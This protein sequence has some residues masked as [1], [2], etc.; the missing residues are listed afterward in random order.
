MTYAEFY[1][2]FM[3]HPVLLWA[4]A[5]AGL[6]IA[7]SRRGLSKSVRWFCIA[8]TALSLLD[9]WLTTD[10]VPGIGQL[11]GAAASL[12]PLAFVLLGDFR[13]FLF[14][15]SAR[16]DGT[17][18]ASTA[19]VVKAIGWTLVVPLGSQLVVTG[20]ASADPRVLF[21][22]YEAL[23][24]VLALCIYALYLPRQG[25]AV[26]WTRRV[27]MFVIGYYALWGAADA[28]ILATS[29]DMGFLLRVLPNALYYGGLVPAIAWTAP[30]A[31]PQPP[32]QG[33]M[34]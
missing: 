27:T 22:V 10:H 33:T 31:S 21:L 32:R 12:V 17:L 5:L 9:A 14:I 34:R 20:I 16:S 24:A 7:L 23:F 1:G 15:E 26:Q 8:L 28:I 19:G 4:S 2:S 30:R 25:P 6:L 3:Q 13:Y 18:A 11:T 29:D